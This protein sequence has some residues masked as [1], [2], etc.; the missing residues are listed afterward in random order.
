V[1]WSLSGNRIDLTLRLDGRARA[2]IIDPATAD[3]LATFDSSQVTA[4]QHESVTL[5]LPQ[6]L[7]PLD[8]RARPY[9]EQQ[10]EDAKERA[11]ERFLAQNASA[12]LGEI[13]QP[14]ADELARLVTTGIPLATR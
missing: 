10:V 12:P 3:M 4:E 14:L 2:S 8:P 9:I 11:L 7:T 5:Q 6:G 1:S 13:V